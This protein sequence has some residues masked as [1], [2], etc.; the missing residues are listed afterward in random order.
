M[1]SSFWN[2]YVYAGKGERYDR[3]EKSLEDDGF[4]R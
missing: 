1:D 3:N 2:Q 4:A